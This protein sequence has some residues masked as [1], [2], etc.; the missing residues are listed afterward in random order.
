MQ[1]YKKCKNKHLRFSILGKPSKFFDTTNPDWVPTLKLGHDKLTINTSKATAP[2]S[3]SKERS[4]KKIK[5]EALSNKQKTSESSLDVDFNTENLET[6]SDEI[7]SQCMISFSDTPLLSS[8]I[9]NSNENEKET[10]TSY[11]LTEKSLQTDISN[12]YFASLE[13]SYTEINHRLYTLQTENEMLE[14]GTKKCF[15]END[16]KVL[17]YTG[18][19][20]F[21]VLQ[22]AFDFLF[23]V[24]GENNRA[25]LS[26]FQEMGLTLMRL[27]LNLTINDNFKI[28]YLK[29]STEVDK[30]NVCKT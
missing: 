9:S 21:K 12:E 27:R 11:D 13:E 24:V 22:A 17:F 4:T 14:V 3:W 10:Q 19:A 26:P 15:N 25:V 23:A 20:N 30:Y 7:N 29:C 18:L 6:Y 28:N 1:R 5:L 16:E 8:S 2:Y